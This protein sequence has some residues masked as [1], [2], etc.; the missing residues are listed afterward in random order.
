MMS[1]NKDQPS[2][3]AQEGLIISGTPTCDVTP[4]GITGGM[5][6]GAPSQTVGPQGSLGSSATCVQP[7][8]REMD[9]LKIGS[10]TNCPSEGI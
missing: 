6:A 7:I 8:S 5:A 3:P 1:Y 2:V 10:I 4:P 9:Q